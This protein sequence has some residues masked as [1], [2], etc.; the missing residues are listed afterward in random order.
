MK[1]RWVSVGLIISEGKHTKIMFKSLIFCSFISVIL[2]A[3]VKIPIWKCDEGFEGNFSNLTT[4]CK[5]LNKKLKIWVVKSTRWQSM[6]VPSMTTAVASS[7]E[8]LSITWTWILPPILTAMTLRCSHSQ[9]SP[10]SMLNLREWTKTRATSWHVP[11]W[12]EQPR[13]IYSMSSSIEVNQE[14]LLGFSGEWNNEVST[15]AA[16]RIN[17]NFCREFFKNFVRKYCEIYR[18]KLSK[19]FLN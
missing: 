14:A 18:G 10:T 2:C 13:I 6:S 12:M 1:I 19:T 11:L 4:L 3:H 16:L 8:A 7:S 17:S 5:I 15:G 9:K